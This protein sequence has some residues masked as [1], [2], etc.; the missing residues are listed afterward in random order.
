LNLSS[1]LPP[2]PLRV[3]RPPNVGEAAPAGIGETGSARV[4][5]F[6]RHVGCPFAEATVRSMRETAALETDLEWWLVSHGSAELT[7][8]WCRRFG[9]AGRLKVLEDEDGALYAAWGLPRSKAAHFLGLRSLLGVARL[10]ARGVRN[11]KASGTRWQTAGTFAVD[12]SGVVRWR[13]LP[14]HAADLPDVR[15]ALAAL[16]SKEPGAA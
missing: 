7:Q 16:R 2:P 5:A 12:A 8:S 14:R 15:Q 11:R 13:H 4:I 9:G 10:A 6:L 1:F 3:A